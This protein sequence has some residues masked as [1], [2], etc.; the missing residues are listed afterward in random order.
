M[1]R[2]KTFRILMIIAAVLVGIGILLLGF[3]YMMGVDLT[4]I[5]NEGKNKKS[6]SVDRNIEEELQDFQNISIE[7]NY[8]EIR[9]KEGDTFHIAYSYDSKYSSLSHEI[10]DGKLV[11]TEAKK[12]KLGLGGDLLAAIQGKDI[13]GFIEITYPKQTTLRDVRIISDIG[14]VNV[15]E[16]SCSN[17]Q[18]DVGIG[19]ITVD[20]VQTQTLQI[21][22]ETGDVNLA[23]GSADRAELE[24]DL[25]K[26]T[27][28]EWNTKGLVAELSSGEAN[29]E[30]RFLGEINVDCELG[31]ITLGVTGKEEEYSYELETELGSIRLNG[32]KIDNKT[33][34]TNAVE[35]KIN[36]K[37]NAGDINLNFGS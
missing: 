22:A 1:N 3:S 23:N 26:L 33:N 19:S 4:N 7:T 17:L 12:D 34:K 13:A 16:V 6:T 18:V 27:T 35:N 11:V 31:S 32:D 24:L 28:N 25:G 29:L 37:T 15:K 5:F 2:N 21:R 9:L 14:K 36:L 30:G 10:K 8:Q 20:D